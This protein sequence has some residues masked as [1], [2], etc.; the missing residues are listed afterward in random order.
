MKVVVT[1]CGEL[2][3]KVKFCYLKL[4]NVLGHL[5]S[6]MLHNSLIYILVTRILV[7]HH[8]NPFYSNLIVN[9]VTDLVLKE[10]TGGNEKPIIKNC[11][12]IVLAHS[13]SLLPVGQLVTRVC[14]P[15]ML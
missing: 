14:Q 3:Q 6:C 5:S 2:V 12:H 8:T 13:C 15:A 9:K 4:L 11:D 10:Y 1:Y 7:S